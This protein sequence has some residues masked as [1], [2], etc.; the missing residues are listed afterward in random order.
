M[1]KLRYMAPEQANAEG[2]DERTDLYSLGVVL[3]EALTLQPLFRGDGPLDEKAVLQRVLHEVPPSLDSLR[4]DVSSSLSH[5]IAAALDKSPD[6]RPR[7]ARDMLQALSRVAFDS[8][9]L[10]TAPDVG[11]WVTELGAANLVRQRTQQLT[12]SV[13]RPRTV[14][15][16]GP[17]SDGGASAPVQFDRPRTLTFRSQTDDGLT[18]LDEL[19]PGDSAI[20]PALPAKARRGVTL[21][22]VVGVAGLLGLVGAGVSW[23]RYAR[24]AS[25][26][27]TTTTTPTT[28]ASEDLLAPTALTAAPPST[29]TTAT[30]PTKAKPRPQVTRAHSLDAVAQGTLNI[31]AEPWAN[32]TLDGKSIGTTPIVGLKVAA[33]PHKVRLTNPATKPYERHVRVAA[34]GRELVTVELVPQ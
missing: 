29:P 1:G 5:L 27:A 34:G 10:V 4:D 11:Q 26:P 19:A 22:I 18:I 16:A 21:P 28:A 14:S 33:G 15:V 9:V 3:Y 13:R 32:A 12:A 30:P 23:S 8:E 20:V 31:Y 7:R 25:P 2:V 24:P 17:V 6:R